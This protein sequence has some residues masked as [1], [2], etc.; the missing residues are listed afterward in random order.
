MH[1][2]THHKHAPW[3]PTILTIMSFFCT[4]QAL[5]R[6]LIPVLRPITR[7]VHTTIAAMAY[8]RSSR[9]KIAEESVR[10]MEQGTYFTAESSK[11]VDIGLDIAAAVEAT[12][13]VPDP[14][15]PLPRRQH[16]QHTQPVEAASAQGARSL[17]FSTLLLHE[18]L[19]VAF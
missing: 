14:S 1:G 17:V 10:I 6:C 15:F 12:Y 2:E 19:G 8:N 16:H 18:M 13:V 9:R 7:Q 5:R 4:N 3:L 11:P